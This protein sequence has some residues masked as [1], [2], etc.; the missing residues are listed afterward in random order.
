MSRFAARGGELFQRVDQHGGD[1]LPGGRRMNVEHVDVVGAFERHEADRRAFERGD[2]RQPLARRL[3]NALV[4]GG[5]GPGL[6]LRLAVVVRRSAPRCWR[7]RFPRA[8]AR[9]PADTAAAPASGW[10]R[11][12]RLTLRLPRPKVANARLQAWRGAD[13]YSAA[14]SGHG[15]GPRRRDAWET[16]QHL[17]H[18]AI[19]QVVPSLESFSTTPMAASSSRMRSDSLK[20]F[21]LRAALR[22]RSNHRPFIVTRRI[23]NVAGFML[24]EMTPSDEAQNRHGKLKPSMIHFM[25]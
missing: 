2:E 23:H 5:G 7:G 17:I 18:R 20:F 16:P 24:Q 13:P 4:I 21:A 22:R 14:L 10:P 15:Y 11:A 3:P 19:S 6:L 8:A 12:H 1:A 9:R 25:P